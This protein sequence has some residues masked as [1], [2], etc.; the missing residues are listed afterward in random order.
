M[1]NN[2]RALYRFGSTHLHR[3]L[4]Q[5]AYKHKVFPGKIGEKKAPVEQFKDSP[6]FHSSI[7]HQAILGLIECQTNK[8]ACYEIRTQ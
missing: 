6:V 1:Y 7:S 5:D 4:N 8:L 2:A 3:R